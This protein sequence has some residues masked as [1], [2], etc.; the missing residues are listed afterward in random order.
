MWDLEFSFETFA[1]KCLE[2]DENGT[3]RVIYTYQ[4]NRLFL[5]GVK[6]LSQIF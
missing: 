4:N 6:S 5:G 1:Q 3:I 2:D